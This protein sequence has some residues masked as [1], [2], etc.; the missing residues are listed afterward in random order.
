[1]IKLKINDKT[2]GFEKEEIEKGLIDPVFSN[3][4]A[5]V[6]DLGMLKGTI[7]SLIGSLL[8]SKGIVKSAEQKALN[9]IEFA[10]IHAT[11]GI[12]NGLDG[13]TITLTAKEVENGEE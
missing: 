7:N 6:E 3:L 11:S 9:N 13:K 12:M 4:Q 1:M 5:K 2:Y 10:F 8:T